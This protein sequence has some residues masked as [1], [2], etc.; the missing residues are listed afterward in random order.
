[1]LLR[2][3]ID[4]DSS[5]GEACGTTLLAATTYRM[6]QYRLLGPNSS[7]LLSKADQARKAI[8]ENNIDSQGW[9]YPVVN[10]L[11]WSQEGSHSPEGQAFV[12]M[13]EAAFRDY[14]ASCRYARRSGMTKSVSRENPLWRNH[15][16]Q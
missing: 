14:K 11:D 1:M 15:G 9:L 8:Y 16:D 12:L 10:P 5:F 3:Y 13:M 7:H 4:D 6:A 2:N